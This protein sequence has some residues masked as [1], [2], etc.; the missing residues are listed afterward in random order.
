VIPGGIPGLVLATLGPVV[1]V[2]LAIVSQYV[3]EGLKSIGWALLF[4]VIGAILYFPFR[5]YL[6]PGVPDVDPYRVDAE[7][8]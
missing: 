4:M 8:E 7:E 6:K 2:L 1:I 3:T 5:H